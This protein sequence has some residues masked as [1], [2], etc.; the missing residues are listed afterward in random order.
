MVCTVLILPVCPSEASQDESQVEG[1]MKNIIR[2][3]IF[4]IRE[5]SYKI[6]RLYENP[7]VLNLNWMY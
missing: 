1:R 6:K 4:D 5:D 2:T 7:I 3:K